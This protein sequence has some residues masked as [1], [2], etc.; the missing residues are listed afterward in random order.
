MSQLLYEFKNYS[1][2]VDN[3]AHEGIYWIADDIGA[4]LCAFTSIEDC[5]IEII[6]EMDG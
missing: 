4:E 5:L 6:K 2:W 1:V 3:E